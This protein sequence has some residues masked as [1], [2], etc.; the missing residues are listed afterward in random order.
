MS[1]LLLLKTVLLIITIM[2]LLYL[3]YVYTHDIE[4]VIDITENLYYFFLIICST[5]NNLINEYFVTIRYCWVV[6]FFI[7]YNIMY[8]YLL[9]LGY[10]VHELTTYP[11]CLILGIVSCILLW[12]VRLIIKDL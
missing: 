7:L 3:S 12:I 6:L 5:I 1:I 8:N 11:T 2:Y 4:C 10:M 9:F